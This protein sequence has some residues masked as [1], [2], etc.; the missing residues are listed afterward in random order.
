M[1]DSAR[2]GATVFTNDLAA[3]LS[4][5]GYD[6]TV[7]SGSSLGHARQ[8]D[9]SDTLHYV[10]LP[11]RA[12]D[13]ERAAREFVESN[14]LQPLFGIAEAN[15]TILRTPEWNAT[16]PISTVV[17][18]VQPPWRVAGP[19]QSALQLLRDTNAHVLDISAFTTRELNK[20]GVR[21]VSQMPVALPFGRDAKSE[22]AVTS[23]PELLWAGAFSPEKRPEIAIDAA[24]LA[25]REIPGLRLRLVGALPTNPDH[26]YAD[27]QTRYARAVADGTI[28]FLGRVEDK[29]LVDLYAETRIFLT[30]SRV[31]CEGL[32]LVA[33]EAAA[34]GALPL[35]SRGGGAEDALRMTRGVATAEDT[36]QGFAERI[37]QYLPYLVDLAGEGKRPTLSSSTVSWTDVATQTASDVE[38][39][40]SL[41]GPAADR[42]GWARA[43]SPSPAAEL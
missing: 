9:R 29:D 38:R 11:A 39:V 21:N 40:H 30:T 19:D 31:D 6:V 16:F 22:K 13:F 4:E 20:L 42:R 25:A 15:W 14:T 17:Y 2:R 41:D 8:F 5:I 28:E 23:T 36:A 12:D 10:Q 35:A 3:G 1:E 27:I 24:L 33:L 34:Q 7:I 26:P 18:H 37:V 32:G 43:L